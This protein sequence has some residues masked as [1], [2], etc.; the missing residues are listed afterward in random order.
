LPRASL[1]TTNFYRETLDRGD[2]ALKKATSMRMLAALI[3]TSGILWSGVASAQDKYYQLLPLP[4]ISPTVGTTSYSAIVLSF[5]DS[6]IY[7]CTVSLDSSRKEFS[8]S[9]PQYTGFV[10]TLLS[11]ANV[12]PAVLAPGLNP[13]ITTTPGQALWQ[14]DQTSGQVQF[15]EI[16]SPPLGSKSSCLKANL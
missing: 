6:K 4:T 15:C 7:W 9:C 8:L 16:G 10:G 12:A 2:F 14:I 13:G 5:A 1:L 11:G 3:F